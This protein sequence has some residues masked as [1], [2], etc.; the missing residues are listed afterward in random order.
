MYYFKSIL[1]IF[2]KNY[3]EKIKDINNKIRYTIKF[4]NI[5]T[6]WSVQRGLEEKVRQVLRWAVDHKGF[7]AYIGG[8]AWVWKFYAPWVVSKKILGGYG[9]GGEHTAPAHPFS[10]AFTGLRSKNITYTK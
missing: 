4:I 8:W 9:Y 3:W 6:L 1:Y 10:H 2:I 7:N 5:A